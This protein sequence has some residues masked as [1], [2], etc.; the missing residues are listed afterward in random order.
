MEIEKKIVIIYSRTFFPDNNGFAN[1]AKGLVE[2]ISNLNDYRLIV[3]TNSGSD[4]QSASF[5]KDVKILRTWEHENF[6]TK[7]IGN[8]KI[9]RLL[10]NLKLGWFIDWYEEY[11]QFRLTKKYLDDPSLGMVLFET[12]IYPHLGNWVSN[13]VPQK[14]VI[15]IHAAEDTEEYVY[16]GIETHKFFKNLYKKFKKKKIDS[17]CIKANSIVSTNMFHLDFFRDEILGGNPYLIWKKDYYGILSNTINSDA[18]IKLEKNH[19]K[20]NSLLPAKYCLTL[21]RLNEVGWIQKGF[22]DL[23]NAIGHLHENGSLPSDFVLVVV[24]EGVKKDKLDKLVQ[25]YNLSKNILHITATSREETLH[26]LKNSKYV[27]LPS[28]FEGQSM[29]LTE[30][31]AMGSS[32]ITTNNTGASDIVEDGNNGF[33]FNAGDTEALGE[34]LLKME[35]ITEMESLQFSEKSKEIYHQK[36]SQQS[37]Q[38][39]FKKLLKSIESNN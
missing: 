38:K 12:N 16:G 10:A 26:M 11:V 4:E 2:S 13:L 19:L 17:F 28:R 35:Q 7:V 15:R 14:V 18:H 1:A 37:I 27:V 32:V 21:G 20:K 33:L 5:L 34:L 36:F 3:M 31:I 24:G 39:Q 29:F 9:R 8:N 22:A 23:I 25:N 6:F 30:A